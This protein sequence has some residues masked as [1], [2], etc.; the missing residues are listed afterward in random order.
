M[1]FIDRMIR[2]TLRRNVAW[3][4]AANNGPHVALQTPHLKM[5]ELLRSNDLVLINVVETI[6]DEADIPFFVADGHVSALEGS[7]GAF[8]RRVLVHRDYGPQARR[9]LTDAGLAAELRDA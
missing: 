4:P 9:L 1:R 6:L 2:S 5:I 7:V 3:R 8:Q